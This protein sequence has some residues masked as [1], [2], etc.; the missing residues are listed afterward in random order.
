MPNIFVQRYFILG[1]HNIIDQIMKKHF[2]IAESGQF[3]YC[4]GSLPTWLSQCLMEEDPLENQIVNSGNF[5]REK[6]K[7][8]FSSYMGFDMHKDLII[9]MARKLPKTTILLVIGFDMD[10]YPNLTGGQILELEGQ[11]G[12]QIRDCTYPSEL[13][14][15]YHFPF[16]FKQLEEDNN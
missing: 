9:E 1:K 10:D 11:T 12:Y 7:I 13:I 2:Y 5:V 8:I 4:Q 15:Q 6:N 3:P 14:S 16:L